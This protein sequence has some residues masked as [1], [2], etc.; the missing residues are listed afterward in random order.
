MRLTPLLPELYPTTAAIGFVEASVDETA[1]SIAA[2][3]RGPSAISEIAGDNLRSALS[4]LRPLDAGHTRFMI[5]P[6]SGHWTAW[7]DNGPRGTDAPT[8]GTHLA[9]TLST[10]AARVTF[11]GN[12]TPDSYPARIVE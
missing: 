3:W 10:R 6:T 8:F 11:Q 2:W 12:S 9:R 1:R 7:F 5:V 4:R